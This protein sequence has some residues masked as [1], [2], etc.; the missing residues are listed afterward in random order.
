MANLFWHIV[1]HI[2]LFVRERVKWNAN[3]GLLDYYIDYP[4]SQERLLYVF[5]YCRSAIS[6]NWLRINQ[7]REQNQPGKN[8]RTTMVINRAKL[9]VDG[10]AFPM[11]T[12]KK[13]MTSQLLFIT[14]AI[15]NRHRFFKLS[16][17]I[18]QC[19][20]MVEFWHSFLKRKPNK[21]CINQ[22]NS[23]HCIA[24]TNTESCKSQHERIHCAKLQATQ[25]SIFHE[26]IGKLL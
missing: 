19:S 9:L 20:I 17:K 6:I 18:S 25:D 16:F 14:S 23:M 2:W 8:A 26:I 24:I 4:M 22:Q 15:F 7:W 5:I 11:H 10:S 21:Q 1:T 12:W 13:N 3:D